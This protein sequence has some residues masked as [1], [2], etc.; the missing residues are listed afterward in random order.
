MTTFLG[1]SIL[2]SFC[3]RSFSS[4]L[5]QSILPSRQHPL[6][7]GQSRCI[8]MTTFTQSLVEEK[9]TSSSAIAF[10][11]SLRTHTCSLS[12]AFSMG[13]SRSSTFEVAL[14]SCLHSDILVF[15]FL[16]PIE[17]VPQKKHIPLSI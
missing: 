17:T 1:L 9:P 2:L 13:S 5:H 12:S 3:L 15:V 11:S 4:L 16:F 8:F 7:R 10:S 6:R 14:S